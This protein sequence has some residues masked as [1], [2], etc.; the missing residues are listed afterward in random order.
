M[1]KFPIV[2]AMLMAFATA[3]PALAAEVERVVTPDIFTAPPAFP[4]PRVYDRTAGYEPAVVPDLFSAPPAFPAVRLYNWTGAY[5]GINGGAAWGRP[6]WTSVPDGTSGIYNLSGGL[7]G[8]TLG[9]NLQTGEPFVFGVETDLAW[10]GVR[11][12]VPPASCVPSCEMRSNW[13]A[14]ARLRF[15]FAFDTVMPYVTA[16][17]AISRL[18]AITAGAPFGTDYA[19]NLGWT[20]GLG[21]EF[22]IRGPWTA[23]AEY[24]YADFNGFSCNVAC[25]GGPISIN[26]RENIVRAGLN[27]R[28]WAR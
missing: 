11:G 8:G 3:G 25:G 10:S 2:V 19:N 12:T 16:G 18:S 4:A 22:V 9:Y 13:L 7:V 5:V 24:L 15:G 21:V 27:Y 6:D 26:A 20:L 23:K 14:T 1:R 28:I 17:A